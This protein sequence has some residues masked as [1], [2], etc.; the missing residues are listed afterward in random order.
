MK[1][2][3]FCVTVFLMF[4]LIS[5][6]SKTEG[7][8]GTSTI[9]GKVKIREYNKDFTI[10]KNEYYAQG[11]DVYIIYGDEAKVGDKIETLYDGTYKFDYLQKGNY[12]VYAY[13]ADST[14]DSNSGY[15]PVKKEVQILSKG[16][17]VEVEDITICVATK[18]R[19]GN[20][21]ITGHV[22]AQ[23]YN[24]VGVYTG[25]DFD[26]YDEDVFL[27]YENET[28][29]MD[30]VKTHYDGTYRF[31]NLPK[32]KYKI[33]AYT[34]VFQSGVQLEDEPVIVEV[35]ITDNLQTVT[36]PEIIIKK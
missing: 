8:G 30:D 27:V 3:S 12:T 9:S 14:G 26:A 11:E 19:S 22:L 4:F 31:D 17:T 29:Y 2:V 18:D 25:N 36:A 13:S 21:T 34:K 20:S 23:D 16:E 15:V 24:S 10:L 1:V 28:F 35:T 6:C 33:Y 32:G 7:E 5:S